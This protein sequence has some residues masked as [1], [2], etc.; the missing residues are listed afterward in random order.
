MGN[1]HSPGGLGRAE[2]LLQ[3]L[4]RPEEVALDRARGQVQGFGD[5]LE[6]EVVVMAEKE[7]RLLLGRDFLQGERDF[8]LEL[9]RFGGGR[10]VGVSG[11]AGQR[12]VDAAPGLD[13]LVA[14]GLGRQ[15]LPPEMVDAGV[16]C[17][18]IK[19]GAEPGFPI[20]GSEGTVDLEKDLLGDVLGVDRIADDIQGQEVDF[21]L[22]LLDELP[23]GERSPAANPSMISRSSIIEVFLRL[24]S[25]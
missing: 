2:L 20:E 18:A 17:D 5:F 9:F 4:D 14:D 8:R 7:D 11:R 10:R 13:D 21:S 12:S 24:S 3:L 6:P 25:P 22:V 19:P 16:V 23:K 15:R 1:L